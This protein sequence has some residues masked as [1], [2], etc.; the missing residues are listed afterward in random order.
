MF[1]VT[2]KIVSRGPPLNE[3]TLTEITLRK[4]MGPQPHHVT[5]DLILETNFLWMR[6]DIGC[7]VNWIF[8]LSLSNLKAPRMESTLTRHG[9]T[10]I[11]KDRIPR[12]LPRLIR[13][14]A[15]RDH[16]VVPDQME[17]EYIQKRMRLEDIKSLDIPIKGKQR[18]V[19]S[20]N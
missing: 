18:I 2:F 3:S 10:E 16:Q 12:H 14:L 13:Q 8:N 1:Q 6:F 9:T 11:T 7:M 19:L 15:E 5:L 20:N 17:A 4:V